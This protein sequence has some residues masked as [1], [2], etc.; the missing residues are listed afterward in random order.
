MIGSCIFPTLV[1]CCGFPGDPSVFPFDFQ[2]YDFLSYWRHKMGRDA[3]C[4]NLI[5]AMRLAG[6]ERDV[7]DAI[8]AVVV[9]EAED[10]RRE[11]QAKKDAEE[12]AKK[13]AA[14]HP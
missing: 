7:I 3:N 12:Q 5:P 8:K 13:D 6:K 11:M 9:E 1:D 14:G 10:T 4:R 2:V